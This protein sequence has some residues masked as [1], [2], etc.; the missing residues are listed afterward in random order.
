MLSTGALVLLLQLTLVGLCF[1][2]AH[3]TIRAAQRAKDT[4]KWTTRELG[5]LQLL[6]GEITGHSNALDNL[7]AQVQKLRGQFFAFKASVE[8]SAE[9]PAPDELPRNLASFTAAPFC[10]NYGRAQLEGPLSAAAKCE[11]G[12]CAEMRGRRDATRRAL[13]PKTAAA[14]ARHAKEAANGKE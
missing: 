9:D 14:Q 7:T 12:Y 4:E 11:C 3:A 10:E 13:I 1:W 5:R 6:R 2:G 8:D